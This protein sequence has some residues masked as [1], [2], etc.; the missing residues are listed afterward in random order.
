MANE[1]DHFKGGEKKIVK[2]L[3]GWKICPLV[4]YDLRFPVW[5]RNTFNNNQLEYDLLLFVAN[6]PAARVNAWDILLKSRAIENVS[7]SLG[8]NRVGKDDND[9]EYNGHSAIYSP[10][11]ETL[12]F[13][14]NE[15][16]ST[17]TLS[18]QDLDQFRAKFPAQLDADQFE[19]K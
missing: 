7:F 5:S 9:I 6:W 10:K 15:C 3:K 8:L 11:G 19:I 13:S 12:F 1:H 18:R 16:I 14:E 2:K 17:V 4:C